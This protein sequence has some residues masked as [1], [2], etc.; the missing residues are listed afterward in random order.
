MTDV[1]ISDPASPDH[2]DYLISTNGWRA[3][4]IHVPDTPL[5]ERTVSQL[6]YELFEYP[7]ERCGFITTGGDLV[8][9]KNVHIDNHN[10][11]Y[12]D[13]KD[14]TEA[15]EYIY[16]EAAEEILG[17]YHTHPNGYPWPSPRDIVGWPKG[18]LG[19]RY[20]LVTRGN[21]SEWERVRD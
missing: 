12:M 3:Q 7:E 20:F 16:E 13:E 8:P 14:G 1:E 17:I 11:F 5:I 15:I 6:L 9:V 19:W 4:Q 21:V 10:N 18:D 2:R